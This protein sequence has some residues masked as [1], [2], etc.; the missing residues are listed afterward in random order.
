VAQFSPEQYEQIEHELIVLGEQFPDGFKQSD[1]ERIVLN[2]GRG[3]PGMTLAHLAV[4]INSLT[5]RQRL[6]TFKR[7]AVIVWKLNAENEANKLASLTVSERVVYTAIEKEGNKGIWIK[8]L[9]KRT[10]ITGQGQLEKIMKGLM[11]RKFVKAEKSIAGKNKKV[12]MLYNLKPSLEV[13]G[14]VWYHGH[15]MDTQFIAVVQ[16]AS[17]FFVSRHGPMCA[18]QLTRRL[19]DAQVCKDELMLPDVK[20]VLQTLLMD[21]RLALTS[22]HAMPPE[23]RD[24]YMRRARERVDAS[25]LRAAASHKRQLQRSGAGTKRA[26]GIIGGDDDDD[27][28]VEDDDSDD[29]DVD[30]DDD[31]AVYAAVA[32]EAPQCFIKPAT[33]TSPCIGCKLKEKCKPGGI[34]EPNACVYLRQWL[35]DDF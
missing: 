32:P 11:S 31:D 3:P 15:E 29:D 27:D 21:G 1:I 16:Q 18:S 30:D 6:S 35:A 2:E 19:R 14:G 17:H 13:T 8:D 28:D 24:D 26:R 12:Y 34:V 23:L 25:D 4:A 20:T 9:R 22:P 10:N 5:R 33:L 7:D